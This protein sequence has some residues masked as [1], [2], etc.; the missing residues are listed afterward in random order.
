MFLR[1]STKGLQTIQ[2][3]CELSSQALSGLIALVENGCS[4]SP[5]SWLDS[6]EVKGEVTA[7]TVSKHLRQSPAFAVAMRKRP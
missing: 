1:L 5:M 4:L 6:C 2:A 7:A 3:Q